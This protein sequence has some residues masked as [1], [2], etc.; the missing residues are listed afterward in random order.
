MGKLIT[1]A[2][3]VPPFPASGEANTRSES[4]V[5]H[6]ISSGSSGAEKALAGKA[7]C[8]RHIM[9]TVIPLVI[10][11]AKLFIILPFRFMG[12]L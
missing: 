12:N 4:L 5:S 6:S 11:R 1:E 2:W 3:K 8:N 7:V 9:A 10:N